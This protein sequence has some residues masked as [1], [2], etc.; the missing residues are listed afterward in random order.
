MSR[1][2]VADVKQVIN[3]SLSDSYIITHIQV[4]T[5]LVDEVL[6]SDTSL[7]S[8]MKKWI[9]MYLAAHF[10]A[11]SNERATTGGAVLER[12]AGD[13][14]VRYAAAS[15][16]VSSTSYGQAAINLDRTGKLAQM[17]KPRARFRNM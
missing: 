13:T 2:T 9:E 12:E 3:T 5:E 15:V 6:G 11:L 4:A 10:I 14:R 8:L 1:V 17:G 7:T 16:A